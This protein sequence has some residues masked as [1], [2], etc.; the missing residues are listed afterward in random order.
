MGGRGATLSFYSGTAIAESGLRG[1]GVIYGSEALH[2]RI[3]FG[4]VVL[5]QL[6]KSEGWVKPLQNIPL[7]K[8]LDL[9]L[10]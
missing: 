2:L 4:S 5:G 7:S 10:E 8:Y 6:K 9:P 3:Y 1:E